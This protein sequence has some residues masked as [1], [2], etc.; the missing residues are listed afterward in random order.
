MTNSKYLETIYNYDPE[1]ELKRKNVYQSFSHQRKEIK[2]ES[3][4]SNYVNSAYSSNSHLRDYMKLINKTWEKINTWN[5]ASK[6]TLDLT[7]ESREVQSWNLRTA[8]RCATPE[9]R[10]IFK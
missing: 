9:E 5:L 4:F 3:R 2:S 1:K 6:G 8:N 7:L 10:M